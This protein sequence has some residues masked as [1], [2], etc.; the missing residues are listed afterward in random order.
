MVAMPTHLMLGVRWWA[1]YTA[2]LGSVGSQTMCVQV[3]STLE[4]GSM[5]PI[6][7]P[8]LVQLVQRCA[9]NH[10]SNSKGWSNPRNRI[11]PYRMCRQ[12]WSL[13]RGAPKNGTVMVD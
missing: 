3:N 4:A 9:V 13:E 5:S 11:M 2:H 8:A 7:D 12:I 6:Q 10:G 1:A